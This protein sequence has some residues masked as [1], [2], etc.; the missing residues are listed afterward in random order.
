MNLE[1]DAESGLAGESV[2]EG[3]G[4][5]SGA[6]YS[7][8]LEI[9]EGPL[10]LLLHLIRL[11]EVDVIDIPIADIACQY[12]EYLSLMRELDL[13]VAGE[14][15]LM[16]A[17]L[18]WIK[19]RM[20][21]P[22]SEGEE[23]EEEGLDPRAGLIARLLEYQRFKDVA[24]ELGELSLLD[25]DVY[26]ARHP[27]L[28]ATPE[29]ERELTVDLVRL[30]EAFR[31]VLARPTGEGQAHEVETDSV[32][33]RERMMA[34]MDRLAETPQIEFERIFDEHPTR[35]VLVTT[36]LALLELVRLTAVRIYQGL[37]DDA[38]PEGPIH[39]RRADGVDDTW[40]QRVANI[41]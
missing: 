4:L 7:V 16:A 11:N 23:D 26:A 24:G 5:P 21:L 27:D 33:V 22:P 20:V 41:I 35:A 17:T 14:Y 9:F 10:D 34:I 25:R 38:V 28:E 19:S 3:E 30:V 6:S 12:I 1:T 40:H 2:L 15:L 18:A 13:D 32:T 36:F 29:S 31:Q 39:L 37:N 8:K